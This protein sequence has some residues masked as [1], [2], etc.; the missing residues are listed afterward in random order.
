MTVSHFQ[1]RNEESMTQ[2]V[3]YYPHIEVR[4]A[5]AQSVIREP[6]R[7]MVHVFSSARTP[8]GGW[9]AGVHGQEEELCRCSNL[10]ERLESEECAPFYEKAKKVGLLATDAMMLVRHVT[11]KT[12]EMFDALLCTAPRAPDL[13]P[14]IEQTFRRRIRRIIRLAEREAAGPLVLGAWG[15]GHFKNDPEMVARIQT[16]EA[17]DALV[18]IVF[19][20]PDR[21]LY[22]LY[23]GL[24][25][26]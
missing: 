1:R 18:P 17:Q 15:C 5:K 13:H 11:L 4:H 24:V 20:L 19:A 6:C 10:G 26:S 3:T 23:K 12:G 16:E 7:P 8:G 9:R 25:E 22:K 21:K 14:D 2:V